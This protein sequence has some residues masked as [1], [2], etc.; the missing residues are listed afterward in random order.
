M[1]A[2]QEPSPKPSLTNLQMSN[3]YMETQS[4]DV[5]PTRV[6][7]DS[8]TASIP[9][10]SELYHSQQPLKDHIVFNEPKTPAIP[11]VQQDEQAMSKLQATESDQIKVFKEL[12]SVMRTTHRLSVERAFVA[13]HD[14]FVHLMVEEPEDLNA[15]SAQKTKRTTQKIIVVEKD[16]TINLIRMTD[17]GKQIIEGYPQEKL[18]MDQGQILIE[19]LGVDRLNIEI[20][21]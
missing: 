13:I 8:Q 5:S 1:S 6:R 14:K 4:M 17:L 7:Q 19:V 20:L 11:E 21:E 16:N 15:V 2:I 18:E 10:Q 3:E 12:T 9:P